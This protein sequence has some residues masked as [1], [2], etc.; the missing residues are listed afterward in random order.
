MGETQIYSEMC[1]VTDMRRS[2]GQQ[3]A[4]RG[5]LPGQQ[6]NQSEYVTLDPTLLEEHN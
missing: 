5:Y 6:I 2:L 4:G 3:F 1:N